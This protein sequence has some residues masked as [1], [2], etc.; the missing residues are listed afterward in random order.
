MLKIKALPRVTWTRKWGSSFS[1]VKNV[2]EARAPVLRGTSA[3]EP[4]ATLGSVKAAPAPAGFKVS[5]LLWAAGLATVPVAALT[6]KVLQPKILHVRRFL[7]KLAFDKSVVA[8]ARLDPE[9]FR[10]VQNPNLQPD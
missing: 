7:S 9:G 8:Q 10:E 3:A 5:S 1:T 6:I 2:A 4:A